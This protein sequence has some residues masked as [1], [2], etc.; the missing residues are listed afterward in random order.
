M[1]SSGLGSEEPSCPAYPSLPA[2]WEEKEVSIFVQLS[3][4]KLSVFMTNVKM[5]EPKKASWKTAW[6]ELIRGMF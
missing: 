5:A 6:L 4:Q 1:L 2:P 3:R